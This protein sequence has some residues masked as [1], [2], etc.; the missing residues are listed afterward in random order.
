MQ[1]TKLG[2]GDTYTVKTAESCHTFF[3]E[4]I[5]RT[6]PEKIEDDWFV[7]A[8]VELRAHTYVSGA[9]YGEKAVEFMKAWEAMQ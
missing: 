9:L 4:V 2:H 7:L 6:A 8:S 1:I 5:D 3:D